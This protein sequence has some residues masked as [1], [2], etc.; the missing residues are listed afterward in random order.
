MEHSDVIGYRTV[1]LHI[2][3]GS[4]ARTKAMKE[5]GLNSSTKLPSCVPMMMLFGKEKSG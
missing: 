3:D 5:L 1:V 4:G 2:Q